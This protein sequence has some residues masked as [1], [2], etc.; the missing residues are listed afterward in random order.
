[1]QAWIKLNEFYE[2]VESKGESRKMYR[3]C[4]ECPCQ[5]GVWKRDGSGEYPAI[6]TKLGKPAQLVA[7]FCEHA[8]ESEYI[9]LKFIS[10]EFYDNVISE[11]YNEDTE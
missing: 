8:Q 6:G 4:R 1:M 5:L 7:Q 3:F 10:L 2:W 9:P 11:W